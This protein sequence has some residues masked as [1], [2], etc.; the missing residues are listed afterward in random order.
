MIVKAVSLFLAA[1]AV[2]ALF[3]RLRVGGLTRRRGP[4]TARKCRK[5][6]AYIVGRGPCAC[7][8]RKG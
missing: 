5:C 2:L 1:M 3:G 6:G 4:E 7:E 8:K